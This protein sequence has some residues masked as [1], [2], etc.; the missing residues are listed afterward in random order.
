[1]DFLIC[2][3]PVLERK[4]VLRKRS[5]IA[6]CRSGIVITLR[7]WCR[8]LSAYIA[9]TAS[10]CSCLIVITLCRSRITSCRTGRLYPPC[11]YIR[12]PTS[13]VLTAAEIEGNLDLVTDLILLQILDLLLTPD[14]HAHLRR[15]IAFLIFENEF[16]LGPCASCRIA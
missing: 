1:M 15:I 11:P 12:I 7:S 6:S 13:V 10:H 4:V 8:G 3:S 2:W 5:R 9:G 14:I 16:L